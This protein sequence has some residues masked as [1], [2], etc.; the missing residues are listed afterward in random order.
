MTARYRYA[1]TFTRRMQ[2]A[3]PSL[4]QVFVSGRRTSEGGR[5]LTTLTA[6]ESIGRGS[7]TAA[8]V[9]V[10]VNAWLNVPAP[11]MSVP[12]RSQSGSR[13][14][15]GWR[16]SLQLSDRHRKLPCVVHSTFLASDQGSSV[17]AMPTN[18]PLIPTRSAAQP[19]GRAAHPDRERVHW[20]YCPDQRSASGWQRRF[21]RGC[22]S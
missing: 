21:V 14:V 6:S 9:R 10:S 20:H 17:L 15:R 7:W 12:A 2:T 3:A 11:M 19:K 13:S 5:H 1:P 16:F 8:T 4:K 22:R 18:L